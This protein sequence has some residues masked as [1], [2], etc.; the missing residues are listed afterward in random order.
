MQQ[1]RYFLKLTLALMIATCAALISTHWGAAAHSVS[2]QNPDSVEFFEKQIRPVLANNCQR[3][4]NPQKKMA[5]LDQSSAMG[6]AHGGAGGALV[7][8]A[9]PA[10]S[11]LLKVVSFDGELKMPPTG[12]LNNEVLAALTAW[13]RLGAPWPGGAP[14]AAASA[15]KS[16]VR[17]FTPEEKKYWAFQPLSAAAVPAVKNP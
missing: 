13:V 16:T 5:G 11:L 8:Q 2:A 6:F 7:N 15:I 12:K 3:C 9:N 17:E 1:V 10:A 14:I 4:H